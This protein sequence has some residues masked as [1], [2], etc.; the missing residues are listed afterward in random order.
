MPFIIWLRKDNAIFVRLGRTVELTW[1]ISVLNE[2]PVYIGGH[3]QFK[4]KQV[5]VRRGMQP[6]TLNIDGK[7]CCDWC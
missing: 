7:V 1:R 4:G 3:P 5:K 2:V 6:Q